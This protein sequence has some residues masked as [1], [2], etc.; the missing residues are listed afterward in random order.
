MG[1][2]ASCDMVWLT[3]TRQIKH[4]HLSSSSVEDGCG[5]LGAVAST[6]PT[7]LADGEL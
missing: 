7:A 4:V 5:R 6:Q 3:G 1:L 2:R